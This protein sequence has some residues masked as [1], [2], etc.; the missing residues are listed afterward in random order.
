MQAC[1]TLRRAP[2]K[3]CLQ[4]SNVIDVCR[5]TSSASEKQSMFQINIDAQTRK[6]TKRNLIEADKNVFDSAQNQVFQL[7]ESDP[8]KRFLAK[9]KPN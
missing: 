6:S 5:E 3:D 1:W 2:A 4:N 7:M 8:Y 9:Q